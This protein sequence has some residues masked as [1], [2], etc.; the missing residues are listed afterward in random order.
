MIPALFP[1]EFASISTSRNS[2]GGSMVTSLWWSTPPSGRLCDKPG[3][4][5]EGPS[6]E[7]VWSTRG[8]RAPGGKT[9][10]VSSL[11]SFPSALS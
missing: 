1:V 7:G 4:L 11:L 3:S 9:R 2:A 10:D 8:D 5:C 6:W